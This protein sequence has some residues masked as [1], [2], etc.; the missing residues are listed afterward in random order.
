MCQLCNPSIDQTTADAFATSFMSHLNG[1]ALMLMTSIGHRTGLWDA[2]AEAGP[3]TSAGLAQHAGL[4]ERY[5]RE[6]LNAM[7]TG[8]V[9]TYDPHTR[10]Y[11]LPPEHAMWLRSSAPACLAVTSQ[12][13]QVLASVEDQITA[14]FRQGGGVDYPA[15]NRFH[16]VMAAESNQ[17]TVQPLLD[18]VLPLAPGLIAKLEAGVRCLDV[19]C[20]VGKAITRM[21]REFPNSRFV[22]YDVYEPAIA[23]ARRDAAGLA[24]V[25]FEVADAAQFTDTNA[26]DVV[27]TFDAVHDQAD[28]QAMLDNI[29]R[30][31]KPG[32]TYFMQDIAGSSAVEDNMDLPLAPFMYTTSTMH[33]MTVSL[34][35]NGA[36]LGTMWGKEKAQAML[37][38]AGFGPVTIKQHDTDIINYYYITHKP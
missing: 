28:P 34:A 21:A 31:L 15:F 24:N 29:Y 32:G 20:G 14:C 13:V 25:R 36:G 2:M 35:K 12:W 16:E 17:S 22:G 26:F 27:F 6:W 18:A 19:G 33:C 5:V 38:A 30:A 1:A 37:A 11:T 10:R 9:V 3:Q 4:Q 23:E 8:R 7:T